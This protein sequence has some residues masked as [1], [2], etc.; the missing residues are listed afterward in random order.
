[1]D[2]SCYSGVGD[3][4]T[5]GIRILAV[6]VA[7]AWISYYAAEKSAQRRQQI[8][9]LD[10]QLKEQQLLR[11]QMRIEA[12]ELGYM[13]YDPRSESYEWVQPTE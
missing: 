13:I 4:W 10:I 8:K 7:S 9:E 2:A 5:T 11:Q 12:I 3:R 6:I 1:M